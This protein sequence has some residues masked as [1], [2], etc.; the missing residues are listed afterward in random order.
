MQTDPRH[1]KNL[2]RS[3]QHP[4]FWNEAVRKPW[5][6]V[7]L[8]REQFWTERKSAWL[9][10]LETIS[11]N[12]RAR[13]VAVEC[14]ED[15]PADVK[16]LV[17]PVLRYKIVESM[18]LGLL[19]EAQETGVPFEDLIQREETIKELR[20]ARRRLD[21]G[22]AEEAARMLHDLDALSARAGQM[23]EAQR[24]EEE[25]A[26]GRVLIDMQ[27]LKIA[28]DF[29]QK[30]KRD[31]LLE[32][33]QGRAEEALASW[34]QG[35]D[36]L[37]R[38]RPPRRCTREAEMLATLQG[39]LLR[40]LSQAA[41]RL[42][43]WGEALEASERALELDPEDHKAWFRRACAL[44][45]MSDFDGAR[46]CLGC[47][48]ELAVGRNDRQRLER[49]CR[50]KRERF[51]ALEEHSRAEHGR[52][53]RRGCRLG[54]F[55]SGRAGLPPASPA[56]PAA[57]AAG[58]GRGAPRSQ[59]SLAAAAVSPAALPAAS[60]PP[61]A[62]PVPS[63]APPSAR[64]ALPAEPAAAAGHTRITR[65]GASDLLDD[66]RAA[67]ADPGLRGRVDKLIRDVRFDAGSFL[68]HIGA[69]A[70]P[71]QE[72]VLRK[73]GF[74]PSRHGVAEMRAAIQDHTR[75]PRADPELRER[76]DE[77]NGALFGSPELRMRERVMGTGPAAA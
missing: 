34:R 10:Q 35:D 15:C 36:A 9:G 25:R 3:M 60:V 22:G 77:V 57:L 20:A 24:K 43:R 4:D 51:R 76:A 7:L 68:Q 47:V 50:R 66:L 11:R 21:D 14:L 32:W 45:G 16:R 65:D 27:G 6:K 2:G 55:G 42:E 75:G 39:A 23:L 67:Y 58:G 49:D 33:Q 54:V 56:T 31:G 37:R 19:D 69:V 64:P 17:M 62:P 48:E 8:R 18:V 12:N 59:R 26:R 30:A 63:P 40:N 53:L 71:A 28:L 38:F 72:P 74:D 5:A 29:G 70:L 61:A 13:E 46:E 44:E 52:M 1:N 41:L 73:W